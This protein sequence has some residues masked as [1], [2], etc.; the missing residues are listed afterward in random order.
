MDA[1]SRL[2]DIGKQLR[3]S[4]AQ[5][6]ALR[7][8]LDHC[9]TES[10]QGAATAWSSA[11]AYLVVAP[12]LEVAA[13]LETVLRCV[14]HVTK[15]SGAG[16]TMF[17]SNKQKLVFRYLIGEG[18]EEL[19]G[20]EVPLEGSQHGLAYASGDIQ[21]GAPMDRQTDALA[22]AKFEQVLVAPLLAEGQ[23]IGTISAVTKAR[24]A[25]FTSED[26]EALGRFAELA[27]IVVR[28]QVRQAAFQSMLEGKHIDVPV[29]LASLEFSES[30]KQLI[31]LLRRI[32]DLAGDED[33]LVRL[34]N[35][36]VQF[37]EV[38]GD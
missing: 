2:E 24:T 4:V 5:L 37:V 14:M 13:I 26:I 20:Y 22:N 15:A 12:G 35:H 28:Q 6:E 33:R 3:T 11:L 9:E 30:Q 18:A 31:L 27:A 8:D 25:P 17:D 36:F 19:L 10:D 21:V 1:T 34:L 23:S 32:A 38:V 29:E 16:L 7:S